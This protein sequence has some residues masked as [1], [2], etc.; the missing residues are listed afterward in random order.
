MAG[1]EEVTISRRFRMIVL[2]GLRQSNE[3][4]DMEP[5]AEAGPPLPPG[6]TLHDV[7]FS[8]WLHAASL[9]LL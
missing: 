5:P 3:H 1:K 6:L 4:K 7:T 2:M 8:F 9:P